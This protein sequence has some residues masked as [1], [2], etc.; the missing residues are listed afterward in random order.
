MASM[1]LLLA[2]LAR[3][4]RWPLWECEEGQSDEGRHP[5]FHLQWLVMKFIEKVR[6]QRLE[7]HGRVTSLISVCGTAGCPWG[8]RLTTS[9]YSR[10]R[11]EPWTTDDVILV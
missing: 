7:W 4:D 2:G 8:G 1:F 10:Y 6:K 11:Q 5:R 3:L 9:R